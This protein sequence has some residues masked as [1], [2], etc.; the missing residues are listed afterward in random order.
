MP[1]TISAILITKNASSTIRR[2][3]E[4]L[5]GLDHI[6]VHDT[7]SVD[8]TPEIA[9]SMGADVSETRIEP[10]HYAKARN[11]AMF[12]SKNPW[13]LS[14]DADETLKEGSIAA[15]LDRIKN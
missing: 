9:R 11:E 8:D 13:I 14:I 2:C 10:F 15:I 1:A 5:Q 12:R 6:V 4:S 3:L 7:G